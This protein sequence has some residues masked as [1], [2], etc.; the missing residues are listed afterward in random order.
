MIQ[1]QQT[2]ATQEYQQFHLLDEDGFLVDAH[3]WTRAFSEQRAEEKGLALNS[4]H[5][6]LIELLRSKYLK[7]GALPPMRTVCKSVGLNRD[8]LKSHFGSCLNLWKL[9]GLPNPG[10]EAI[11]YM[12]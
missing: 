2:T 8:E 4:K 11:T 7:L 6:Q 10:E 1:A 9:A 5:W 12:N 3:E